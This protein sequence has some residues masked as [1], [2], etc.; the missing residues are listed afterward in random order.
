MDFSAV[1]SID[2]NIKLYNVC[3]SSVYTS[4]TR[5][6]KTS[7][8]AQRS[9]VRIADDCEIDM[10]KRKSFKARIMRLLSTECC[11]RC[12]EI[13]AGEGYR[14][15]SKTNQTMKNMKGSEIILGRVSG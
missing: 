11:S 15:K 14:M 8:T 2:H 9:K 1:G 3:E 5:Q 7:K 10:I 12:T 4:R 13:I 6:R